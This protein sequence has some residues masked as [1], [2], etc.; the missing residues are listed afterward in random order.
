MLQVFRTRIA[1]LVAIAAAIVGLYALAGFVIAPRIARNALLEDI[2]KAVDATPS[3]GEIRINPFLFQVDVR[4]FA[5]AGKDGGKLL[6]F[7]RLFIDFQLSSIWHR[8]YTF[9]QIE[10]ESPYVNAIVARDGSVNLLALRPKP[11]PSAPPPAPGPAK[12]IPALRVASFTVSRGSLSYQDESRPSQFAARLEPINFELKDF[13]TGIQGGQFAFTGISKL[14]ERVEWHGHLSVQPIESDGE[15]SIQ[16][17]RA[18]TLWEYLEDRLNF[19]VDSGT[20]DLQSTYKFALKDAVEL[21]MNLSKVSLSDLAVKPKGSDAAWVSVPALTIAGTNVDLS[22]RLVQVDSIALTGLKLTTWLEPD[23]TLNLMQL[24]AAP[25]AGA[26][27]PPP[28]QAP[29]LTATSAGAPVAGPAADAGAPWRVQ[30]KSFDL[31]EAAVSAEDRSV[32]PAAKLMLAPLS[33][34]V[35]GAS[36][37]LSKPVDVTLDT[38]INGKGALSLSGQVTPQPASASLKVKLSDIDMTAAQPYIGQR[39]ALTLRSGKLGAEAQVSYSQSP[40]PAA[41]KARRGAAPAGPSFSLAGD[42]HV[43]ALH[44]VDDGLHDDLVKWDRLDVRGLNYQSNPNRLEIAELTVRKP[45]ARV[46]IEADETLNVSKALKGPAPHDAGQTNAPVKSAPP[47]DPHAAAD[48]AP[49]KRRGAPDAAPARDD[50]AAMP[51]A[52]KKVVIQDGVANFT[53]LSVAPHFSAAIQKLGGSVLGLSS[54]PG[55]R[56]TVDL[57]GAVDAFSPVS[58]KGQINPLGAPLYVDL[59][60]DF[61]NMELSIFNPYSGKFAGY[62]ITK[63][64]LTTEL[65]YK[66][67]GRKL[68]AQHHIIIDQLEFGDKT[69]SKQAVSL[70]VKLAVALLKDRNGVI[71]L[72]L[73]VGGS[74]DDPKFRLAPIIWKVF[75]NILEKAVTAPFALLGSLFGGGPD[76]QFIDF[77]PGANVIDPSQQ[78][79]VKAIVKA[80][81]ERPQIKIEVPIA[82]VPD[83][84]RPALLEAD[85]EARRREAMAQTPSR[86][87][88]APGAAATS[89]DELDPAAKLEVLTRMYQQERGGEPKYPDTVTAVKQKPDQIAAKIDFLTAALHE[90]LT[91]ADDQFRALGEQRAQALQQALLTGTQIDSAR[92]FLVASDKAAAKDGAVRL[93]LS[94]R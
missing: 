47:Q 29:T 19:V 73:P 57:N 16:G 53:D 17:L 79:K 85:F 18:H 42:V 93:E 20:I 9:R 54:K 8:A 13:V 46:I 69:D 76:L 1:R 10:I 21:D 7:G 61:R 88:Q 81:Q 34:K 44:T 38:R 25:A 89:F 52:I 28:A 3:V 50:A 33:V 64:K 74:L 60:L 86:K 37:D 83:L 75:V 49:R 91:V 56:A 92:V 72:N 45:Y 71:D 41:G 65:H 94:L 22:Q 48:N 26:G 4:D 23:G 5:L 12:P 77:R 58:I 24:A 39:T 27:A 67:D 62:N 70:P 40:G 6:G 11:Q 14:G 68:D 59:A 2:P 78:D 82:G 63:G 87:K 31:E 80:L 90:Q 35:E 51:M 43:E 36:L 66:V 32:Q 30:L 84:D 55:T 15:L